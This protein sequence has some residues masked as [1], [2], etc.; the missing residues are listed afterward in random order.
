MVIHPDFSSGIS[1]VVEN[2]LSSNY[3]VKTDK[4]QGIKAPMPMRES[5]NTFFQVH[6]PFTTEELISQ[7]K[8]N[9]AWAD[10][11][12]EE[13]V[14]GRPLN[15][16]KSYLKWPFYGRDKEMRNVENK[17]THTYMERFWP[18]CAGQYS[19]EDL[20]NPKYMGEIY[21]SN[22]GIRYEYGDLHDLIHHL[23]NDPYSR[24]AFLPIWFPEDTGVK[25]G[26]RVPC[27]I[28]YHFI[29]RFGVLNMVYYIRS[30]DLLRHFRD[31][32]YLAVKLLYYI[33]SKLRK[34]E[35]WQ[36]VLPGVF[37]MHITSLH[38]FAQELNVL[39]KS[40]SNEP[41]I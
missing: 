11:H 26:G 35:V 17:F 10:F 15:P 38:I 20:T 6:I 21:S 16:G 13:R 36:N 22:R 23:K 3:E 29:L 31:D 14:G 30:C 28:G 19:D 2:F 18:K 7:V 32:I 41:N 12:F 4:W 8:P 25:H 40:F 37:T 34:E 1:F 27:S 39:T 9:L 33:L 24:Q 5:L